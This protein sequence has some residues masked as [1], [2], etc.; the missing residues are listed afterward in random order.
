M[1]DEPGLNSVDDETYDE[2]IGLLDQRNVFEAK[3]VDSDWGSIRQGYDVLSDIEDLDESGQ[4]REVEIG[5]VTYY[6]NGDVEFE[7]GV[8]YINSD[9]EIDSK[10]YREGSMQ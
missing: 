8:S 6:A 9:G 5:D 7:I 2:I 10:V 4:L 1:R 3:T